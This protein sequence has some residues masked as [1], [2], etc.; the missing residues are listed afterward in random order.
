MGEIGL[1]QGDVRFFGTEQ[2]LFVKNPTVVFFV[3][4]ECYRESDF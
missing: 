3:R 2:R 4:A 1:S